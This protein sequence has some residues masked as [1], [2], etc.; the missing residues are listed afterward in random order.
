MGRYVVKM[1]E[2]KSAFEILA[3]KPTGN[4]SLGR[5]NG[6]WENNIRMDLNK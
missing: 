4:R 2:G 3:G 5:A 1:E 6:R